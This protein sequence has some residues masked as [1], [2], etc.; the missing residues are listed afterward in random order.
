MGSEIKNPDHFPLSLLP[1]PGSGPSSFLR[2]ISA[3]G[4]K[5]GVLPPPIPTTA[6]LQSPSGVGLSHTPHHHSETL[7]RLPLTCW[8]KLLSAFSL[9][10]PFITWSQRGL[11]LTLSSTPSHSE[12]GL[13]PASC[14]GADCS[15]PLPRPVSGA[16]SHFISSSSY[17]P[18]DAMCIC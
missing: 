16:I 2:W 9:T 13:S 15:S 11:L 12:G 14:A 1:Q 6:I 4:S 10:Q 5:P 7:C 8:P 3:A 17:S 18:G